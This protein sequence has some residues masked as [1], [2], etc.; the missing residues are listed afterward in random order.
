MLVGTRAVVLHTTL[1]SSAGGP[2]TQQ[3]FGGPGPSS[4]LGDP[5]RVLSWPLALASYCYTTS[6]QLALLALPRL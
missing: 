6:V 2:D 1:R 3:A 5:R 4:F